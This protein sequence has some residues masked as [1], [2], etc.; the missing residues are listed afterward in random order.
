[1][2]GNN[3]LTAA[4]LPAP[5][6]ATSPGAVEAPTDESSE[7]W[8]FE[9]ALRSDAGEAEL[10]REPVADNDLEN[11]RSE[12][13]LECVLRQGCPEVGMDELATKLVPIPAKNGPTCAGYAIDTVDREGNSSRCVFT[14]RSLEHV[15]SRAAQRLVSRGVLQAG[16]TYHFELHARRE[17]REEEI[18]ATMLAAF[19]VE[20]RNH[21]PVVLSVPLPPLLEQAEAIGPVDDE[22][23]KVFY[24]RDALTS[25]ESFAR[26][27]AQLQPP[28]ETGAV[29]VGAVCSCPETHDLFV[30]VIDVL[31]VT[32]ARQEEFALT[33][34]G[35]TWARI[36]AVLR[37]RQSQPVTRAH[38]IV[39]QCHCHNFLPLEGAP[40]C[41][42]CSQVAVCGRTS[43]FVSTDDA[44][45][46][47]AVFRQQ[48]WQLS[49][50]FGLN[51]REEAVQG[52]FALRDGRLQQRGFHVIPDFDEEGV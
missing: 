11:V 43:V 26:K 44:A 36:Q 12:A 41:E 15:A 17:G 25:A 45:W 23:W 31:E 51:A 38:R 10:I 1:M 7:L 35:K 52:L 29:L 33:Y 30:V 39:G 4:A 9:V 32:D 42:L 34:S 24:T 16:D 50:I 8:S 27:G 49:H 5:G 37:A 18:G 6:D 46:S 22:V 47:R 48:P 2:A 14:I 3:S 19:D 13:W 40:P 20:A 28:V 21:L